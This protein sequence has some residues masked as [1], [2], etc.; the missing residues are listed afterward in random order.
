MSL[1]LGAMSS[2]AETEQS[3]I[4]VIKRAFELGITL[5]NS[6]DFYGEGENERLIGALCK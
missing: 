3:N 6:A 1:S 4:D 2:M 5:V